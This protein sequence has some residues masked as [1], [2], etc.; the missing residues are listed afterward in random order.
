V[1]QQYASQPGQL[2]PAN[3]LQQQVLDRLILMAADSEG[4]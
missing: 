4:R 1:Q 3:V 2:P